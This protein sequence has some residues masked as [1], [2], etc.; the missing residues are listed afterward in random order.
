MKSSTRFLSVFIVLALPSLTPAAVDFATEI[1]PILERSC[2]VCHGKFR[3]VGNRIEGFMQPLRLDDKN[4]LFGRKGK[5]L[6]PGDPEKSELF[7]R[8]KIGQG[9]FVGKDEKAGEKGKE[10]MPRPGVPPLSP[11]E[12]EKFRQWI[13][14]GAHW[15]ND[16]TFETDNAEITFLYYLHLPILVLLVSLVYHASRHDDWKEIVT[17]GLKNAAY[18]LF[19][20]MG[21][22][23]LVMWLLSEVAP[24]VFPL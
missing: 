7:V 15:P 8:I 2:I 18:L 1:K 23:F 21:T 4:A 12:I 6:E 17:H 13:A 3:P 24:S 20:F 9:R 14:E 10:G 5:V 22:V 11:A 19:V 16:V